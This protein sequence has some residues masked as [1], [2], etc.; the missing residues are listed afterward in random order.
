MV[1]PTLPSSLEHGSN[2]WN[3]DIF[4]S[5]RGED[6]RKNFIDHLYSALVRVGIHTF[7]DDDAL[8]RGK[9]IS[10]ELLN[11]IRGSRISIVVFSQGYASSKW[12]LDELVE[13]VH[14][15]NT[16][17]HTLFPVFYHVSPSDVRN[18]TGT[19]TESFARHAE[20]FQEDLMRVKRWRAA[21]T[22]AANC[23]G[24]DLESVSNGFEAKFIE[25]I[26]REILHQLHPNRL[27]VAKH[28]VGIDFRIME[29]KALLNLETNDVR[30]V[31][32]HGMSG[33]GKTVIAKAVYNQ[34]SDGF[35]GSSFLLNIKE[36]SRQSDGLFK[37]QKI[38]LFDILKNRDF[39][40][41]NV[42]SGI[43]LI[44]KLLARKKVLVVLDDV[45]HV[46]QL[47]ALAGNSDWFGAGSRII[48][49]TKDEHLL[50][51]LGNYKKYKVEELACTDSLELFSWHAFKMPHPMEDYQELSISVVKY[52][53]GHPLA[54]EVLGS[55]LLGRS[56]TE[57]KSTVEKLQKMPDHHI[58]KI[59]RV[60]FDSLDET[61][62]DIFLDI[63]C[64]FIGMDAKYVAKILDGCGFFPDIGISN[65][66]RRSVV[67]IDC[68]NKLR[69]H[70]LI[71]DIG[72]EIVRESSCKD[73]GRRSRL[74]FHED[75]FNVLNSEHM[76]SHV[77]EG[78]ML[79]PP[80]P[81]EIHLKT[82]AFAKMKNLRLLQINNVNLTGRFE[83]LSKELRWLCWHKCP[84]KILPPKFHLENLVVLDLQHSNFI[85]VWKEN[86]IFNKLKVLNLSYSKNLCKSPCFSQVP[87]L[88]M[89]ILEGC[90]SLV[91][92][93]DSVR[94]LEGLVLL[95]LKGCK[96]LR[97][98]PKSI[99][100]LESL[101]TLN[102]SGC[103][104]LEK[105]PENL[106]DM[107]ALKELFIGGTAI[108][109][110]PS[111]LSFLMN[112]KGLSLSECKEQFSGSWLSRFS[113]LLS[114]RN[115][116]PRTLLQ[117]SV[118]GFDTLGK[119]VL[120]DCNLSE[121]K[122]PLDLGGFPSLQRLDLSENNF[123]ILPD[124]ISG[125]SKLQNLY[126]DQC[127]SLYSISGLPANI[128][129]LTAFCCSSL[130]T[131]SFSSSSEL[132]A[133]YLGDCSNLVDI[134]G[135]NLES[136]IQVDLVGC[137]NLSY[138]FSKSVLQSTRTNYTP[139][140]RMIIFPTSDI[141]NWFSNQEMGPSISFHVPSLSEGD[142]R[143][144]YICAVYTCTEMFRL[145]T[146]IEW[147]QIKMAV[148]NKTKGYQQII[149]P[150]A[151][152]ILHV[153]HSANLF[154]FRWSI[155]RN[156][157]VILGNSYKIM[158]LVSGDEIEF[159]FDLGALAEV[160][161]CGVHV[162][163]DAPNIM[164]KNA[165]DIQYICS[166]TVTDR[167]SEDDAFVVDE[168][169]ESGFSIDSK[170]CENDISTNDE[171]FEA[172]AATNGVVFEG[173]VATH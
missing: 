108:K 104:E 73:L 91:E 110:L 162:L 102:L 169:S 129:T 124:G 120:R 68:H 4:L 173:H 22:E 6:T 28:P 36:T 114:P 92:L 135:L 59:L 165:S 60:S 49:T 12:C 123:R 23:S 140:Y 125:L 83:L 62:M 39:P 109:Q 152:S 24:W 146:G 142:F 41:E 166:D 164:D 51:Q 58:Q 159:S 3:Y 82:D 130:E 50:K 11:A 155:L 35:E 132:A 172:D 161:K 7:R 77:V 13:I 133:L 30:I 105:L 64:F 137:N 56:I 18:Q 97:N 78:L 139:C 46:D 48:A 93:H 86:M 154:L 31:S 43:Y 144:L 14:C 98:L 115:W 167:V 33:I 65:L 95:N 8:R 96:N 80:A 32:V 53:G 61:T 163:V 34:I 116:N 57:W 27:N 141:P 1:T 119:L 89:L 128:E 47:S 131:L 168:V 40:F 15:K 99:S 67:T 170:V 79:N 70:D 112:W 9:N 29:M 16:K 17:S 38:L 87:H 150:A 171:I 151:P 63:A 134:Q 5:F 145:D 149:L 81:K 126:L 111:S 147:S 148:H 118:P 107:L 143:I 122:I 156:K 72:R 121:D 52:T 44:K 19:F 113:S 117:A 37:L 136:N 10:T 26:T 55:F 88:Q 157:F 75:V 42:D 71:R 127:K 66:A 74:W 138:D 160:K 2:Q 101:E 45:D 100:K 76:E 84:L 20:R 158:E 153:N 54:L 103:L 85:E 94:Y 25:K 106:G 90:I 21:L 69:M